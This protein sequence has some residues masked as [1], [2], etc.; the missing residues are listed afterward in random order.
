MTRSELINQLCELYPGVES[1]LMADAV[2]LFFFEISSALQ[3][4]TRV[5]LRG[6]GSFSLRQRDARTGRNPKTGQAV[7]VE[8]KWVPFFKAGKE[9]KEALN[10]KYYRPQ[11]FRI[12]S[13]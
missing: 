1:N 5:E 12:A 11:L 10:Q 9:M 7:S 8:T 4:N 13:L 2:S 6:F 3:R